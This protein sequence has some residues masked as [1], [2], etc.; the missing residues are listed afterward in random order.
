MKII[1]LTK[2]KEALVDDEL[3]DYLNQWKWYCDG[4][5]AKREQ[6]R[7]NR[8]RF[9]MHHMIIGCPINKMVTDHI[10]GNKLDNRRDNLRICTE[11]TNNR[12]RPVQANSKSG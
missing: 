3:F 1:N 11:S 9:Y 6:G 2:G 4:R 12:N 10:N 5:Y 8:V 7:K